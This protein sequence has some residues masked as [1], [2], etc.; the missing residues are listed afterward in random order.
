MCKRIWIVVFG[1]A[2][3]SSPGIS[4][5]AGAGVPTAH[6]LSLPFQPAFAHL[7]DA[8]D[9]GGSAGIQKGGDLVRPR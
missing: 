2:L 4:D 3:V 8:P 9:A 5:K 7:L 6:G 1:P